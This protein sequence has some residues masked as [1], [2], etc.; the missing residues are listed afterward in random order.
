MTGRELRTAFMALAT[1]TMVAC[2]GGSSSSAVC[3]MMRPNPW[4]TQPQST[5]VSAGQSAS[6]SVTVSNAY[7]VTYQWAR[8]GVNIAGA[9]ANSYA[10]PPTTSADSGASFTVFV[11]V[12][13][14]DPPP[15][16]TSHT[17]ESSA[18]V[19]TVQ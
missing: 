16:N 1:I 9:I 12:T 19:L 2:G 8:N 5:T 6:F 18:A 3:A 10:T 7:P 11:T 4:V 15:C 13:Y 17:Y 14:P